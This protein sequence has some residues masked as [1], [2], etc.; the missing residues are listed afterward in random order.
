L[1]DFALAHLGHTPVLLERDA[2]IPEFR[3]L[4]EESDRANF[5]LGK[6]NSIGCTCDHGRKLA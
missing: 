2:N 6:L 3:T 1:L 4:L 5:A